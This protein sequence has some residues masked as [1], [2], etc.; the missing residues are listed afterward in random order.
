MFVNRRRVVVQGNVTGRITGRTGMG[1]YR[2]RNSSKRWRLKWPWS[3][4]FPLRIDE[5]FCKGCG[6]PYHEGPLPK[7]I[8]EVMVKSVSALAFPAG[9]WRAGDYAVRLGRMRSG[10]KNLFLSEFVPQAEI[11]DAVTALLMLQED[12]SVPRSS[13]ARRRA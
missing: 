11:D 3:W 8:H 10:G 9:S 7:P 2:S 1:M 6:L 5:R 4:L 13:G 12:L